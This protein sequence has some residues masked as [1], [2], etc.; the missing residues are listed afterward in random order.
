MEQEWMETQSSCHNTQNNNTWNLLKPFTLNRSDALCREE[1]WEALTLLISPQRWQINR[2]FLSTSHLSSPDYNETFIKSS[3]VLE[4]NY[5]SPCYLFLLRHF[6]ENNLNCCPFQ[7]W[8]PS[9]RKVKASDIFRWEWRLGNVK[10]SACVVVGNHQTL[11]YIIPPRTIKNT[12]TWCDIT[13]NTGT[14]SRVD[15]TY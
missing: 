10:Q 1:D 12:S 6:R 3:R 11:M 9:E 15:P 7:H 14:V 8:F 4:N 2:R 13:A 5:P